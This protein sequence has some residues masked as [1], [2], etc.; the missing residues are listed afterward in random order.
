MRVVRKVAVAVIA[1]VA[2]AVGRIVL[3]MRNNSQIGKR[4]DQEP[5]RLTEGSGETTGWRAWVPEGVFE[6]ERGVRGALE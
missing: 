4:I 3:E 1:V 5:K 6:P 2:G